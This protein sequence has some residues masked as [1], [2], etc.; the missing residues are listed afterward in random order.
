MLL[1]AIADLVARLDDHIEA[2]NLLAV[3]ADRALFDLALHFLV[4]GCKAD[5][6]IGLDDAHAF[7][8]HCQRREVVARRAFLEGF[9]RG[10][11]GGFGGLATAAHGGS[12]GGEDLLRL[13]DL[14]AFKRFEPG[15]LVQWQVGEQA[16]E[17]ADIAIVGVAPELPVIERGQL[18]LVQPHG[19]RHG[20]AHLAA[21]GGGDERRGDAIDFG[22][23]DA[24]RQLDPVDDVAPLIRSA[25][26]QAA[27]GAARQLQEV[28]ALEDHV[29]ELEERQRLFAVEPQ[30]DRIEAEHP[31]DR[32]MPADVAQER[33]VFELVEPVGIV[34]HHRVGRAVAKG[35]ELLEHGLDR[36]D[37]AGDDLVG[38][39]LARFVLEAR[40]ADL[41]GAAA[42]QDDRLVAGLLHAAQQH[43]LDQ[44]ADMER[45]RCRIKADIAGHDLL[46]GQRVERG[47]IGDLVDISTLVEQAKQIGR[48]FGHGAARL[49]GLSTVRYGVA[50]QVGGRRAKRRI[51]SSPH[52]LCV[53]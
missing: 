35:Q 28:I 3:H 11:G 2:G 17:A 26:L 22:P 33:D 24:A 44:A 9:S 51:A 25:H 50:R 12:F 21:V 27:I 52:V 43:D 16:Q 49:A 10:L 36:G 13:V 39:Q 14:G 30:L 41:A 4:G 53:D 23:V 5:R 15:D 38:H 1:L 8:R 31:V 42:H 34:D 46:A 47:G 37:V 32:E 48:V 7:R 45:G 18:I 6:G 40:V 19:A 29:V 20:L